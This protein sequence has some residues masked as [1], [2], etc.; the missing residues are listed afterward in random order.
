MK[1][2]VVFIGMP[3]CGKSTIGRL[4]SKELNIKF[5]DMDKYIEDMTSKTIP[6]LFEVGEENFRN[7]ES[8]ACKKLAEESNIIISSGGG[9]V[10]RKENIDVLK[11]ESF[12]IFIDRPL[13]DL[14]GDIDISKRPLLKDGRDKLVRLYEERY[15][16]YRT[17]ADEIIKNDKE[18]KNTINIVKKVIIANL[19]ID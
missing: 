8:L 6:E 7:F 10:K 5:V 4:I 13:E 15:E 14:L 18:I 2:K 3:G 9:V 11:E 12:I 16:L 19:N 1:N 17:S